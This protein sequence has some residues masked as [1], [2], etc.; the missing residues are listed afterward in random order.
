MPGSPSLPHTQAAVAAGPPPLPPPGSAPPYSPIPALWPG[1]STAS[2]RSWRPHVFKGLPARFDVVS[3][4][5]LQ[6]RPR[7][8]QTGPPRTRS[9]RAP[10]RC[11]VR[12]PPR[13]HPQRPGPRAAPAQS[14][15]RARSRA[16][17][18][19]R[20]GRLLR[21]SLLGVQEAGVRGVG[22]LRPPRGG[23][24]GGWHGGRRLLRVLAARRDPWI[25]CSCSRPSGRGP[26][27]LPEV[28]MGL[29]DGIRATWS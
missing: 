2:L 9:H 20:Q 5:D 12:R 22:S 7:Q 6:A 21:L 18:Q 17:P 28:R 23:G 13:S 11:R 29:L 24:G 15:R 4:S 16:T 25:A 19:P 26:A 8:H 3:R 1:L 10:R 14:E 27:L